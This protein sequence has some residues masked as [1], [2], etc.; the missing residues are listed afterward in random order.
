ML[1][2]YAQIAA[3][4]AFCC[5]PRSLVSGIEQRRDLRIV[6]EHPLVKVLCQGF[7]M[8]LEDGSGGFHDVNGSLG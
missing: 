6:R 5:E 2:A 7:S 1:A 8:L 3:A 4:R